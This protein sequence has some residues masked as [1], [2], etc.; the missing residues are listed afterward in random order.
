MARRPYHT[1]PSNPPP[2][3]SS[4]PP[5]SLHHARSI[6]RHR[7]APKHSGNFCWPSAHPSWYHFHD[8]RCVVSCTVARSL[9]SLDYTRFVSSTITGAPIRCEAF[10]DAPQRLWRSTHSARVPNPG[11]CVLVFCFFL[12]IVHAISCWPSPSI[13][14]A[15]CP[16]LCL[17]SSVTLLALFLT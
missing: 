5:R 7:S 14:R 4:S 10:V 1:G 8:I 9:L 2:P 3:L 6:V 15:R 16:P 12:K 13:W 11:V 17:K